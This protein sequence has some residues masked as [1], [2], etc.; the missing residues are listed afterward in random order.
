M[1]GTARCETLGGACRAAPGLVT[2]YRWHLR[3]RLGP[4]H[5]FACPIPRFGA[6]PGCCS[7][8]ALRSAPCPPWARARASFPP[9]GVCTRTH[10][11]QGVHVASLPARG[12]GGSSPGAPAGEPPRSRAPPSRLPRDVSARHALTPHTCGPFLGPHAACMMLA[13]LW[14]GLR[15][16][17]GTR[18]GSL[19]VPLGARGLWPPLFSGAAAPGPA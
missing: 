19:R 5:T 7:P 1:P 18:S 8:P 6:S 17:F 9:P 2:V 11:G 4:A 16:A 13:T 10:S 12:C 14:F 15:P 3:G